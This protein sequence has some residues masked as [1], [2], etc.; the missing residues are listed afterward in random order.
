MKCLHVCM[1]HFFLRCQI[2]RDRNL[3]P[4]DWYFWNCSVSN[5]LVIVVNHYKLDAWKKTKHEHSLCGLGCAASCQAGGGRQ[6]DLQRMGRDRVSLRCRGR[7]PSGL[8]CPA[9]SAAAQLTHS[10]MLLMVPQ[11][12]LTVAFNPY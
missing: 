1:H 6:W 8:Q 9:D 5:Q 11:V 3:S 2:S 12:P 7:L 4:P 10:N